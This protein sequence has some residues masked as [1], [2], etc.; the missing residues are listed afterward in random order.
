M[1]AVLVLLV[2]MAVLTM[3]VVLAGVGC[4]SSAHAIVIIVRH[5]EQA[6][7][8]YLDGYV[9]VNPIIP[10]QF[11]CA[12]IGAVDA[13]SG[14]AS[15][16]DLIERTHPFRKRNE[17]IRSVSNGTFPFRLVWLRFA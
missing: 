7:G 12:H 16:V 11:L 1:E 3:V 9:N 5:P 10:T 14:V 4:S 13:C 2:A 15:I 17:R 8:Q 6:I